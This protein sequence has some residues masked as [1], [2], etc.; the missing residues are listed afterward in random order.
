MATAGGAGGEK[1]KSADRT[2]F[3]PSRQ[4]P[5]AVGGK[6]STSTKATA[7]KPATSATG[8]RR[9]AAAGRAKEDLGALTK[10]ELYKRATDLDIAHRSTLTRD[11]HQKAVA[12]ASRHLCAAS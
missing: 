12:I 6:K 11:E 5:K 7:S 1:P 10:A 4:A 9:T 2:T 3:S 8:E